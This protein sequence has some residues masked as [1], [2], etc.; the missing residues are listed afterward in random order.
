MASVGRQ[1]K[2]VYGQKIGMRAKSITIVRAVKYLFTKPAESYFLPIA[3]ALLSHSSSSSSLRHYKLVGR[4][5]D[6][7]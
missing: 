4:G 2:K 1:R 5:F 3:L 7:L 6:S